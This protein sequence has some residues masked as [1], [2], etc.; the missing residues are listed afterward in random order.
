MFD[1]FI[2][3]LKS[4]EIL[5]T[6]FL[7]LIWLVAWILNATYKTNFDLNALKDFYVWVI[8][9]I[10]AKFLINSGLNTQI[11]STKEKDGVENVSSRIITHF[12]NG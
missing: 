2:S 12:D 9:F 7:V 4:S 6:S 1:K 11:G 10:H 3:Y 8:G 5:I